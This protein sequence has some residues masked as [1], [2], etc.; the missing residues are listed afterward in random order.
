MINQWKRA[1]ATTPE[2]N[3]YWVAEHLHKVELHRERHHRVAARRRQQRLRRR[4]GQPTPR[5][6]VAAPARTEAVLAN[7]RITKNTFPRIS[8]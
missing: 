1:I 7:Q 4:R 2:E 5:R 3:L 8:R 6:L